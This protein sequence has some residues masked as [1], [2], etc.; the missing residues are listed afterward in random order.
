MKVWLGEGSNRTLAARQ[1]PWQALENAVLAIR[2]VVLT[3]ACELQRAGESET[4]GE[5]H[6]LRPF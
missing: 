1:E 6:A 2:G 3:L 5:R 4:R